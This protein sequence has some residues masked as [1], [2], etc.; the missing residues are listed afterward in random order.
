MEYWS[1]AE[2]R[3]R[4]HRLST[5]SLQSSDLLPHERH[6]RFHGF[7]VKL[8]AAAGGGEKLGQRPRAAER[9]RM[10]VVVQGF[11]LVAF[12]IRPHLQR[13][14]LGDAIF[15]VVKGMD[16]N[17]ELPVPQAGARFFVTAPVR[18]TAKTIHER[19]PG[20]TALGARM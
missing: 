20:G 17:M 13:A 16:K 5:P 10:L 3:I 15:D 12:G 4:C 11:R 8:E 14:E 9:Q 18:V 2:L 19:K 7:A 1:E 6:Q